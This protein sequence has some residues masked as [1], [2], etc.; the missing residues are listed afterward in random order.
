MRRRLRMRL[1]AAERLPRMG[2]SISQTLLNGR[3]G[4]GFDFET[5][6]NPPRFSRF[7]VTSTVLT[8]MVLGVSKYFASFLF[9]GFFLPENDVPWPLKVG[10]GN[11][12]KGW[13]SWATGP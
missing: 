6:T 3:G 2:E 1:L 7:K 10:V 4:W 9:S 5:I 12:A 13:G 11:G 8:T